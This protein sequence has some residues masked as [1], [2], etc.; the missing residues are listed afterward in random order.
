MAIPQ[1]C[2]DYY[3]VPIDG[4]SLDYDEF[5]DQGTPDMDALEDYT[6][7]KTASVTANRLLA[8]PGDGQQGRHLH[9]GLKPGTGGDQRTSV[10]PRTGGRVG[11]QHHEDSWGRL[12]YRA[13]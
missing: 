13:D 1:D 9:P 12:A 11:F 8:G 7:H 6:S 10:R 4:R 2:G 5:I 3:W